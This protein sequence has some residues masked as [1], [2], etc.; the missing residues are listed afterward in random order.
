MLFKGKEMKEQKNR[1]FLYRKIQMVGIITA[2]FATIG[3]GSGFAFEKAEDA[4]IHTV[5]HVY[6]DGKY[7]GV[8]SDEKQIEQVTEKMLQKAASEF[9]G[10]PLTIGTELSV[11]PE[12]VFTV[13]TDDKQVLEKLQD[14]LTVE[15]EAIGIKIG[16]ETPLFVKD[17]AEYNEVIKTLMLQTVSQEELAEFEAR[18]ES[19][20]PLPPLKEDETRLVKI[21]FS[22]DLQP[23]EG[24]VAPENVKSVQEVVTLLNKGTLEEKKYE[25]QAGDVLGKIASA[26]NMTTAKLMEQNSGVTE[27][28]LLQIGQELNVTVLEPLIQ[29]EA[30]Y[31][32]KKIETIEF[33]QMTEKDES[34][35]KGEKK[36][37]QKGSNGKKT[38][39]QLIRKKNGTVIGRSIVDE[40]I[41]VES[42]P[43]ITLVG[44]KVIPSRGTGKFMWPADGGYVSSQMGKRWGRVHQGIDIARPSSRSIF[45]A[46]NGVVTSVGRHG[47]YG[48]RIIISHNN[49]YK[50]LY[51]H[52]AKIDVKVGQTVP[53]G[54][55]IGVMGSTGRST[56]MHL[57][58]EVFKNGSNINPL[59]VLR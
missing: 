52:L 54:T 2:L 45:A 41:L 23:V 33:S 25:V 43:E 55:R 53:K 9:E 51:A 32:S 44:T 4:S 22:A 58:F 47:T 8:L 50:T 42:V 34:L 17:M 3:I 11:V 10:L 40:D 37:K 1:S 28:S 12:N 36:L 31:E 57:H 21:H 35:F 48:N 14:K 46:D 56:G 38:V 29:M 49:G 7:I 20:E 27:D 59:T 6:S 30:H 5:F 39:T 15:A 26:H 16:E 19:T 24:Q 13:E 18:N